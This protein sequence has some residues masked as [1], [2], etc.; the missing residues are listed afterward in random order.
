LVFGRC[1]TFPQVF[2]FELIK[3]LLTRSDF[4][5]KFDGMHAVTGAY[6]KSIFV[7]ELGASASDMLNDTPLEVRPV[8]IFHRPLLRL[9]SACSCVLQLFSNKLD[10]RTA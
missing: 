10:F 2:D 4:S 3:S 9:S 5:M 8:P 6:A 7:D 1:A